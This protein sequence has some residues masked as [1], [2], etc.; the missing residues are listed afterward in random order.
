MKTAQ[1]HLPLWLRLLRLS[2]PVPLILCISLSCKDALFAVVGSWTLD[3]A[4]HEITENSSP[5]ELLTYRRRI[6]KHF[7]KLKT[8]IPMEDIV[9]PS[10]A[11]TANDRLKKLMRKAC[12]KGTIYI[13]IPLKFRWPIAGERVI[14]WCWKS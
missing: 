13:W 1:T 8:Y 3:V 7:L 14:D 6:Q 2:L 4:A 10:E 5:R 12:G 9:I 11:G